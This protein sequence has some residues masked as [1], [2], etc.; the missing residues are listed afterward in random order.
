M[1][2][3]ELGYEPHRIKLNRNAAYQT[4][5]DINCCFRYQISG[6]RDP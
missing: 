6:K 3:R 1:G 2:K 5:K 4:Q